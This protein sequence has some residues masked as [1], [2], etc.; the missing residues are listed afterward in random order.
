MKSQNHINNL[1]DSP[2][3]DWRTRMDK[4]FAWMEQK[5]DQAPK[6]FAAQKLP[7][8]PFT[9]EPVSLPQGRH[10]MNHDRSRS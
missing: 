4:W 2:N 3:F 1:A 7:I 9:G 8:D 6:W 5:L 10:G